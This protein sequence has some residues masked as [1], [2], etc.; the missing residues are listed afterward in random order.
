MD[1]SKNYGGTTGK[2]LFWNKKI[3]GTGYVGVCCDGARS[4][5][6]C[7]QEIKTLI[8]L[9]KYKNNSKELNDILKSVIKFINF[10]DSLTIY[11]RI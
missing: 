11:E 9:I 3:P 8:F 6:V 7:C 2:D 4:M 10:I 5:S 1:L